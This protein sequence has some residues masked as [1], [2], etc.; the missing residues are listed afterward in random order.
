[1]QEWRIE[2]RGKQRK[3][4]SVDLLVQAVMQLGRQL[5]DEAQQ[6]KARG[7]PP[8]ETGEHLGMKDSACTAG[9]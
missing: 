1:M 7:R 8:V 3:Q 2:I 6:Q 9:P 4:V 5:Q